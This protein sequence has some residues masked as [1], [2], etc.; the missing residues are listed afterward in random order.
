MM[1]R[2]L[3]KG[4]VG[5]SAEKY[6]CTSKGSVWFFFIMHIRSANG[7]VFSFFLFPIVCQFLFMWLSDCKQISCLT[8]Q[9]K[10]FIWWHI[11]CKAILEVETQ[12][13]VSPHYLMS[14]LQNVIQILLYDCNSHKTVVLVFAFK[15][16]TKSSTIKLKKWDFL[17][18]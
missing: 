10:I 13:K 16:R 17:N 3:K 12:I 15:N 1:L 11:G 2:F 8:P 6:L 7:D 18:I 14:R 9:I 4:L 5:F